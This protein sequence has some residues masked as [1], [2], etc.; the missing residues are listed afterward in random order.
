MFKK[1]YFGVDWTFYL[2]FSLRFIE[3]VDVSMTQFS[4]HAPSALV[5]FTFVLQ[6][7]QRRLVKLA[8]ENAIKRE[9]FYDQLKV[10][11]RNLLISLLLMD[12]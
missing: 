5:G 12:E 3:A 4:L 10:L 7:T 11:L 1:K 8:I 2:G 6:K 9:K